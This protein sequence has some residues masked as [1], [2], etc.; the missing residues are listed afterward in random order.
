MDQPRHGVSLRRDNY[1]VRPK[2]IA[3]LLICAAISS[4]IGYG[5]ERLT[6][7]ST[8]PAAVVKS[9][10]VPY[11]QLVTI[12]G[13]LVLSNSMIEE[14]EVY[15]P[16]FGW[17]PPKGYSCQTAKV[18]PVT[19]RVSAATT[20]PS[21]GGHSVA[22]ESE[23]TSTIGAFA[24]CGAENASV[25]PVRV[26]PDGS[27]TK[28]PVVMRYGLCSDTALEVAYGSG[29]LWVYDAATGNPGRH[30]EL[31][32][33]SATSGALENTIALPSFVRPVVAA[34]SSG[35]WIGPSNDSLGPTIGLDDAIYHVAPGSN[36]AS[37]V[38]HWDGPVAWMLGAGTSMYVDVTTRNGATNGELWRLGAKPKQRT[39]VDDH[40]ASAAKWMLGGDSTAGFF[41]LNDVGI[42]R[43][44]Y[45][46]PYSGP[47]YKAYR[48]QIE[49]LNPQS[50]ALRTLTW[51]GSA[52]SPY[53]HYGVPQLV[54]AS[55]AAFVLYGNRLYRVAV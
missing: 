29:S 42:G 46:S 4:A 43:P 11:Q 35:F 7:T 18:A 33:L 15:G 2:R 23:P 47:T 41:G 24:N 1:D 44:S 5:A 6:S 51:I 32:R 12:G 14:G 9:G 34:D 8:P 49:Q 27:V 36:S 19:L 28:G 45:S 39:L 16:D 37:L 30:G 48:F 20:C 53:Q 13:K 21:L 55:G 10:S 26:G 22:V 50:G 52:T 38:L 54:Y 40:L 31:V 3:W 17:S 25:V